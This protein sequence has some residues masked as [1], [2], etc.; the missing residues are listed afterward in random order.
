MKNNIICMLL[1]ALIGFAVAFLNYI[2]S[3]KVLIKAA[4]KYAFTTVVRQV[5]QVLYLVAVYFFFAD[6]ATVMYALIGAAVGMTLPMFYFTKKLVGFNDKT[7]NK[8]NAK[9]ANED[10]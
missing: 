4:D 7:G 9:E 1:T 3:K 8:D 6:K 5:I 2:I 10:G